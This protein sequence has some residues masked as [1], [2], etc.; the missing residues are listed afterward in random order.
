MNPE[1]I[2]CSLEF[3]QARSID[4]G[5]KPKMA[6]NGQQNEIT[7][8]VASDSANNGKYLIEYL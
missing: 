1:H 7:D 6:D 2:L 3:A 5:C 8:K 4:R